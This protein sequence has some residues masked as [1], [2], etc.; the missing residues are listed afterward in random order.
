ML[1]FFMKGKIHLLGREMIRRKTTARKNIKFNKGNRNKLYYCRRGLRGCLTCPT[2][3][4]EHAMSRRT[5][6]QKGEQTTQN[7]INDRVTTIII[8][9][10]H[11]Y[12]YIYKLNN[13]YTYKMHR[14]TIL[15]GSSFFKSISLYFCLSLL[16]YLCTNID[17]GMILCS[18][19]FRKFHAN[20]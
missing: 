9:E 13:F 7:R 8:H 18:A 2:T 17:N 20:S 16:S 6:V 12:I 10:S 3:L 11:L 14:R 1:L 15:R 19:S 5:A 4:R